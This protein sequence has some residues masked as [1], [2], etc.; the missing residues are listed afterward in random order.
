MTLQLATTESL[1]EAVKESI[2]LS[3]WRDRAIEAY[4]KK[5]KPTYL[6][7][8]GEIIPGI[9]LNLPNDVYHALPALSSSGLKKFS[10]CPAKYYREYL[11]GVNRR[12]TNATNKSLETGSVIHELILETSE[13]YQRYCRE[14][15]MTDK[16]FESVDLLVTQDDIKQELKKLGL[17]VSGS[18]QELI[19]RLLDANPNALIWEH[20]KEQKL[21][22]NGARK[23]VEIEGE[24][25]VTYGGLRPID[26]VIWDDAMRSYKNVQ[27]HEEARETF[28]YGESEVTFLAYCSLTGEPIKCKFDWLRYDDHAADLKTA[29]SVKPSLFKRDIFK[30]R[31]DLQLSFYRYVASCL[32]V[33]I[34]EFPLVALEFADA[35]IVQPFDIDEED[36]KA[37]NDEMFELLEEYKKCKQTMRW[38]GYLREDK[39]LVVSRRK[40]GRNFH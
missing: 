34:R 26:G 24:K 7:E 10:D 17:K 20:I 38:P 23:E 21:L 32:G 22:E 9:Y 30:F 13:F 37:A 27:Q 28:I 25:V 3:M 40:G 12:K 39:V 36:A 4:D 1:N 33:K 29:R 35:D 16:E 15:M 11:S 6:N 5:G 18:K 2:E 14:P 31:Y 8:K 19:K